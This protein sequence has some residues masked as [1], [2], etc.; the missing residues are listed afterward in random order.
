[1]VLLS[2]D[3]QIAK[4]LPSADNNIDV[5]NCAIYKFIILIG[6]NLFKTC[7]I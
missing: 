7:N 1:M 3:I 6:F 2:H 5:L 4:V